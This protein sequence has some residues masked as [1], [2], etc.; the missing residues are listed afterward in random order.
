LCWIEPACDHRVVSLAD[1]DPRHHAPGM[2]VVSEA[3]AAAIRAAY[4]QGGELSA[5]VKLRRLFPAITDITAARERAR[6]IGGWQPLP[7]AP[8]SAVAS[9]DGPGKALNPYSAGR[10]LCSAK[11]QPRQRGDIKKAGCKRAPGRGNRRR[12]RNLAADAAHGGW[13]EVF[14]VTRPGECPEAFA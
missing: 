14:H 11:L 7:L 4:D 13:R 10:R 1:H 8:Q 2:F 5:A 3:E 6:N 9:G 12:M